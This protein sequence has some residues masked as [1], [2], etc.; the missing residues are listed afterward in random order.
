MLRYCLFQFR[1]FRRKSAEPSRSDVTKRSAELPTDS[2]VPQVIQSL[3]V[4]RRGPNGT[5][6]VSLSNQVEQQRGPAR[7]E[8][9]VGEQPRVRR[10]DPLGLH[11]V[12]EPESNP[13]LNLIFVHG[14]GGTSEQTW[15][16]DKDKNKF[17]PREWLPHEPGFETTRILSFGYNAHFKSLG[18]DNILNIGDFAKDLLFAMKY[19]VNDSAQGF[20]IDKVSFSKSSYAILTLSLLSTAIELQ[21]RTRETRLFKLHVPHS[22][23]YHGV[24]NNNVPFEV[25]RAF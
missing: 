18:Q 6:T 10:S 17:W 22:A 4:A 21:R 8:D 12:F 5:N 11:V 9:H 1:K 19:G 16:R 20:Q 23:P 24:Y 7:N 14:L 2:Q 25:Y 3:T 13:T 15:S